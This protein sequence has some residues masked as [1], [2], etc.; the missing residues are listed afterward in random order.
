MSEGEKPKPTRSETRG[1]NNRKPKESSAGSRIAENTNNARNERGRSL[2]DE[3]VDRRL[4]NQANENYQQIIAAQMLAERLRQSNVLS[5]DNMENGYNGVKA[6]SMVADEAL[7]VLNRN[8]G[9]KKG[10]LKTE[11]NQVNATSAKDLQNQRNLALEEAKKTEDSSK[12]EKFDRALDTVAYAVFEAVTTSDNT[13]LQNMM[14]EVAAGTS[15]VKELDVLLPE[16]LRGIDAEVWRRNII[17]SE[18]VKESIVKISKEKEKVDSP[19]MKIDQATSYQEKIVSSIEEVAQIDSDKDKNGNDIDKE[20]LEK[21]KSMVQVYWYVEAQNVAEEINVQQDILRVQGNAMGERSFNSGKWWMNDPDMENLNRYNFHPE[22]Q[23]FDEEFMKSLE[24]K[25]E[26]IEKSTELSWDSGNLWDRTY[27]IQ[28]TINEIKTKRLVSPRS[29][30]LESERL[31]RY[32]KLWE[33]RLALHDTGIIQSR[34][35]GNMDSK[36]H[37]S[38]QSGFGELKNKDRLLTKDRIIFLLNEGGI[39]TLNGGRVDIAKAW[40]VFQM[41][42]FNYRGVILHA[43]QEAKLRGDSATEARFRKHLAKLGSLYKV[44]GEGMKEKARH[45]HT[46]YYESGE[47]YNEGDRFFEV[48]KGDDGKWYKWEMDQTTGEMR[49]MKNSEGGEIPGQEKRFVKYKIGDHIILDTNW[50]YDLDDRPRRDDVK[51]FLVSQLGG[52]EDA[53]RAIE[54]AEKMLWS[55]DEMSVLNLGFIDQDN[56]SEIINFNMFRCDDKKKGKGVGPSATIGMIEN[57]TKGFLRD[58]LSINT[59]E[60]IFSKEI[61]ESAE[62]KAYDGKRNIDTYHTAIMGKI[63]GLKSLLLSTKYMKPDEA[64][65][66]AYIHSIFDYFTKLDIGDFDG[67][68]EAFFV[69]FVDNMF[70]DMQIKDGWDSGDLSQLKAV[71][72]KY[73]YDSKE[74]ELGGG[75]VHFLGRSVEEAINNRKKVMTEERIKKFD[76]DIEER[77]KLDTSFKD[78]FEKRNS[79]DAWKRI[80]KETHPV[81]RG[82]LRRAIIFGMEDFLS[83]ISIFGIKKK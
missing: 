39:D 26:N 37:K 45:K 74:E 33:A 35:K 51:K 55:F 1:S 16:G 22:S 48:R 56:F 34:A 6:G 53:K 30:D 3:K 79:V 9:G 15:S 66:T 57:G 83:K 80:M 82:T 7:D 28:E 23:V 17:T 8:G 2:Q 40:D 11:V 32:V 47:W 69:G 76:E 41:A 77:K 46:V 12:V 63:E 14:A 4:K 38:M 65:N 24:A 54:A 27:F 62:N 59:L 64:N 44:E 60:M 68:K 49:R 18:K 75:D 81:R 5:K 43:I 13:K 25:L 58:S 72:T 50:A 19:G 29:T 10:V 52:T 78:R 71:L 61:R 21:E 20:Q 31:E 36:D 67:V 42:N 70:N 73:A